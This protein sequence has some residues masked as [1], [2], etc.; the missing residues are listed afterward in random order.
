VFLPVF[1]VSTPVVAEKETGPVNPTL[2]HTAFTEF[3]DSAVE[4][5]IKSPV[6]A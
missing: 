2:F 4:L 3:I 1:I 6:A 5:M